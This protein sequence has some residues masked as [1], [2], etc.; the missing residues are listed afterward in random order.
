M[1][2]YI[3][4]SNHKFQISALRRKSDIKGYKIHEPTAKKKIK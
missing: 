4:S 2:A 3:L 1:E